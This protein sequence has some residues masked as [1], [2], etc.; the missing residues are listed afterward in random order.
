MAISIHLD[1]SIKNSTFIKYYITNYPKSTLTT[2]FLASYVIPRIID[3]AGS[4]IKR[5][6]LKRFLTIT[7]P[8]N[9]PLATII[10]IRHIPDLSV[11][12]NPSTLLASFILAG[13]TCEVLELTR[14]AL[15]WG[16]EK[17]SQAEEARG[18]AE[19]IGPRDFNAVKKGEKA[20]A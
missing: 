3:P 14:S 12:M 1:E 8:D 18:I 13:S 11:L 20:I 10:L 7:L 9:L 2:A 16:I 4:Q 17:I 6:F 5:T 19:F 15:A